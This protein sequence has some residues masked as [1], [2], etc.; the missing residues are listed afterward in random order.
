MTEEGIIYDIFDANGK[1]LYMGLLEGKN[2]YYW[3]SGYGFVDKYDMKR[4]GWVARPAQGGP[5]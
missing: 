4:Y 5:S 1:R 2:C 3:P